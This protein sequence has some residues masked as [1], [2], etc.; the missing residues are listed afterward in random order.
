MLN[1][2]INPEFLGLYKEIGKEIEININRFEDSAENISGWGHD[3][4]CNQDGGAL[5][6]DLDKPYSHIC[7]V[8]G[9]EYTGKKYDQCWR[10]IYR[11]NLM[12]SLPKAAYL[13]TKIQDKKYLNYIIEILDFYSGI[14]KDFKLQAKGKLVEDLNIDVGGA[15]KMMPQGLNEAIML[16]RIVG[17]LQLV[18]SELDPEWI[19]KIDRL[20]FKPAIEIL[21]KQ[22]IR[23]HNIAL[24]I[25]TAIGS[26]GLFMEDREL[27][28]SVYNGEFGIKNQIKEGFTEDGFWYEGSIHYNYFALEGVL[29]FLLLS[30]A[31]SYPIGNEIYKKVLFILHAPYEYAFDNLNLPNPNDGWPNLSLKTYSFLYYLAY[32]IYG[33]DI[34]KLIRTIESRSEERFDVALS[35]PYYFENRIP[36]ERVLYA[37]DFS[38]KGEELIKVTS[39]NLE[40]TSYGML[41]N[42]KVNIFF[43]YGHQTASHA[44][45]DKMNIEVMFGK[46]Y[47]TRDLS[48]PGYGSL[49]CNEW[50][51]MSLSHN[52][53]IIGGK[54]LNCI[55]PGKLIK[56]SQDFISGSSD[57][58]YEG[59]KIE[60][61][62]SLRL[63]EN[64]YEDRFK[65]E[66]ENVLS[67]DYIFHLENG[68]KI[69]NSL[70]EKKVDLGYKENGYQHLKNVREI[71]LEG[72]FALLEFDFYGENLISEIELEDKKLFIAESYDNPANKMRT[73][74]II[75]SYKKTEEFKLT[76]KR[77]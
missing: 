35:K 46:K 77:K 45:P 29:N 33:E 66:S 44:H 3:Y 27:V 40:K 43:K 1:I 57:R 47:L 6:F 11:Y 48:N 17:A 26:V 61:T 14:Y 60:Y 32:G 28:D 15:S 8:C 12:N 53:V 49:I 65:V 71:E 73:T 34:G 74:I 72:E 76:W 36:M 21:N 38:L 52:T 23:I 68:I 62:R 69:K 59:E 67:K 5:I 4:F 20:L 7:P 16:V 58:V 54:N 24:W 56:F 39:K 63:T 25:G 9:K 2:D 75:R 18:K 31:S 42:D 55:D 41:K 50:N 22:R 37:E 10:Y 70:K 64:G 19:K 13:Y 30:R 51:R